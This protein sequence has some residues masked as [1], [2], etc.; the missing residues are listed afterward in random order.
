MEFLA[1][2]AS[3]SAVLQIQLIATQRIASFL[4]QP[5][6][7]AR[8]YGGGPGFILFIFGNRTVWRTE[9]SVLGIMDDDDALGFKKSVQDECTMISVAAAIVAQIAMTGFS[10]EHLSETHCSARAFL[11]FSVVSSLMAV[12]YA[13]TQ[14]RI[15]GRLLR[16][17]KI[18]GWIRGSLSQPGQDLWDFDLHKR[19]CDPEEYRST[20]PELELIDVRSRCF[21]PSVASVVALSAP[22]FLLTSSLVSLLLAIG[23]YS[24]FIW[25][26]NLDTATGSSGSRNIFIVYIISMVVCI[27]LYSTCRLIQDHDK[28]WEVEILDDYVKLYVEKHPAVVRTWTQ[29]STGTHPGN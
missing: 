3:I 4:W 2:V 23:I 15:V 7:N 12:Y 20:P 14:Q 17:K 6:I 22:Q 19:P 29:N 18:R 26:R 24:G 9:A 10:L 27:V 1:A 13:T 25:T 16:P 21:T 11:L 28:R 5:V 8:L